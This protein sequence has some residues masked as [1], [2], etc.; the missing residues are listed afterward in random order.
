MIAYGTNVVAGVNPEAGRRN[1]VGV[2]ILRHTAEAVAKV[3]GDVAVMFIPPAMAKMLR[4]LR[5]RR[6]S[7]CWW[8]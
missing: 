8:F 6:V 3:G 1:H 4:C 2:P 7:S 5:L